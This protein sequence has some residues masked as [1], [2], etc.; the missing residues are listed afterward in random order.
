MGVRSVPRAS[1]YIICARCP[2][3]FCQGSRTLHPLVA[4]PAVYDDGVLAFPAV[5]LAASVRLWRERLIEA[6]SYAFQAH[7]LCV[8]FRKRREKSVA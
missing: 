4:L 5:N 3:L 6:S 8:Y 7:S 2:G 1:I